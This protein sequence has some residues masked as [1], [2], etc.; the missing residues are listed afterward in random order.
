M[1]ARASSRGTFAPNWTIVGGC[2]PRVEMVKSG[3]MSGGCMRQEMGREGERTAVSSKVVAVELFG[4]D[5][6]SPAEV[7]TVGVDC[8]AEG[9]LFVYVVVRIGV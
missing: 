3:G 9:E 6:G 1:D 8:L 7:S 5:H 4:Q 2:E